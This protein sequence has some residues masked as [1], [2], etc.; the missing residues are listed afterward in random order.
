MCIS[1]YYGEMPWLALP[2]AQ[3]DL[4]QKL[5]TKFG[6]S[7]IQ[8]Q[9]SIPNLSGNNTCSGSNRAGTVYTAL[10]DPNIL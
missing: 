5:G 6:V 8:A 2:F 10:R 4:K 1:R 3:R 9:L 7:G